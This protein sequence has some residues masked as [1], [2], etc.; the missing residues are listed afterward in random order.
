LTL[1]QRLAELGSMRRAAESLNLTQPAAS[2]MLKEVESQLG[3]TLFA[4]S[5]AGVTPTG[6]AKALLRRIRIVLNE[7]DALEEDLRDPLGHRPVVR[8]GTVPHAHLGVLQG[9]AA[10]CVRAAQFRLRLEEGPSPVLLER[11]LAGELDA[12]VGRLPTGEE[13]AALPAMVRLQALYEESM[14]IACGA[15][16]ALATARKITVDDLG[17]CDWVLPSRESLSRR[18]LED[19]FLLHERTAP[20]PLIEVSSFVY[21]LEMV[22]RSDVLTV[23]PRTAVRSQ[24]RLGRVRTLKTPLQL[25]PTSIYWMRRRSSDADAVL[26]GLEHW[27]LRNHRKAGAARRG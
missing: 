17:A 19:A 5:R 22:A 20:A 26:D 7:V 13:A 4:R 16:H 2:A 18:A 21:G 27:V 11:L 8:L 6:E 23:A 14:S 15:D 9:L 24:E 25:K 10:Y 1:V 12:L 3:T